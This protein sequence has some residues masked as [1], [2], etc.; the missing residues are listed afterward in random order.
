VEALS[1]LQ[2]DVCVL[3]YTDRLFFC[4]VCATGSGNLEGSGAS[5]SRLHASSTLG[6]EAGSLPREGSTGTAPAHSSDVG[7]WHA[8]LPVVWMSGTRVCLY[9]HVGMAV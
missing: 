8:R 3:V 7:E 5:L 1:S 9:A 2:H 6:P 4:M